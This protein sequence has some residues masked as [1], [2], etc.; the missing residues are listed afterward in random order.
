MGGKRLL[1]QALA[2]LS[3]PSRQVV[4]K[5]NASS[6]LGRATRAIS[7]SSKGRSSDSRWRERLAE[8][9][10]QFA[11]LAGAPRIASIACISSLSQSLGDVPNFSSSSPRPSWSCTT[12]RMRE[13]RFSAASITLS[14]EEAQALEA[15]SRKHQS[16]KHS[17]LIQVHPSLSLSL[18]L[19]F[20]SAP[21]A[22][23]GMNAGGVGVAAYLL[24]LPETKKGFSAALSGR[25]REPVGWLYTYACG[26]AGSVAGFFGTTAYISSAA[27]RS[28]LMAGLKTPYALFGAFLGGQLSFHLGPAIVDISRSS[29]QVVAFTADGFIA[30][31]IGRPKVT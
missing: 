6:S 31:T 25:G 16:T 21:C 12:I 15:P 30:D 23:K 11:A 20:S 10:I 13:D 14:A 5:V 17:F 7:R 19:S 9:G 26:A 27:S 22:A 28:P 24:P 4:W 2:G 29:A 8:N 18:S 1:H 3:T